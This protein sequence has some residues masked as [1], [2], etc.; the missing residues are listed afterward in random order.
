MEYWLGIE[1]PMTFVGA[2]GVAG[3]GRHE[4]R[5]DAAGEAEDDR[6]MPFLR[7]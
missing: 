1:T 2:E 5:V 3:D 4:G 7:T 6:G